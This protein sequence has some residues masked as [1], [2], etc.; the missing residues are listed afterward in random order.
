MDPF[1]TFNN[2]GSSLKPKKPTTSRPANFIEALKDF[3]GGF[4]KQAKDISFGVGSS[5]IDQLTGFDRPSMQPESGQI[6]PDKPFNFAEFLKSREQQIKQQERLLYERRYREERLVFSSKQEEVKLQIKAIQEEIKKLAD[7]TDGLSYE[8]KKAA[9]QAVVS[10]GIYHVSFFERIRRIIQ[11]V[12]KQIAES[13]T[14][15]ETMNNRSRKQSY[16]WGRVKQSG[17][18]FMLSQER[19]LSTQVG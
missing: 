4:K 5:A 6:S 19:Y 14:W 11:F 1:K 18:K 8:V 12:R 15:L 7:S 2:T 13:R 16:Y 17:T 9:L 3:K 10:P